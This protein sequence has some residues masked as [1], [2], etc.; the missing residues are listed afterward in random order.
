MKR[1][2]LFVALVSMGWMAAAQSY[3]DSFYEAMNR[4]DLKEQRRVLDE[5][6]KAAP[7]DV[8]WYIARYNY[9]VNRAMVSMDV[10]QED[11]EVETIYLVANNLADSGL[12][13]IDKA[14][15][16]FPR[17]LDLRFGKIYFLGEAKRWNAF[18][19]EIIGTLN[20]SE[21]IAHEWEFPNTEGEGRALMIEGVHDYLLTMMDAITDHEHL[22]ADDSAMVMRVRRV[23]M[24]KVQVFSG[25]MMAVNIVGVTYAIMKEYEKSL[26][27]FKR[28]EKLAPDDEAVLWNLLDAY[29]AM[30]NKKEAKLYQERLDKLGGAE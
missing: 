3:S 28:A 7:D 15:G 5:W 24:R 13:V 20:Y 1:I 30:G 9:F 27:Y 29:T 6:G 12:A 16:L 8:E 10:P 11:G 25:D 19:E 2:I 23:A 17:R 22:T 26:K 18:E 14:I 21:L 4:D